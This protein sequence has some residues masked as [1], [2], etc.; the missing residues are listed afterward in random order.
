LRAGAYGAITGKDEPRATGEKGQQMTDE[1]KK[2]DEERLA[3]RQAGRDDETEVEGHRLASF[4]TPG[5]AEAERQ[6]G[7]RPDDDPEP[8]DGR[9]AR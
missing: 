4:G 5:A 9:H 1:K 2:L 3:N 7:I 6:S 8:A